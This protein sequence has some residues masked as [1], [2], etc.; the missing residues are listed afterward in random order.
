MSN[1][2]GN[3]AIVNLTNAQG[4]RKRPETMLDR[5]DIEG[6]N[7]TVTEMVG[8]GLD[9]VGAGYGDL[10]KIIRHSDYSITVRDFGRG[11]PLGWNYVAQ[12][13]NWDLVYNEMFAG[14]KY[15]DEDVDYSNIDQ[16]NYKFPIGTNGLGGFATQAT[17]MFF[18]VY[19]Y[20][21][22]EYI[23]EKTCCYM[24]FEEGVPVLKDLEVRSLEGNIVKFWKAVFFETGETFEKDGE[25]VKAK[26]VK[27]EIDHEEPLTDTE[28]DW[29][30]GT[31][32]H[33]RPDTVEVFS[34]SNTEGV[35]YEWILEN[36][37]DT[38]HLKQCDFEII[39]EASG[40]V[41]RIKGEGT[42]KLLETRAGSYMVPDSITKHENTI[43]GSYQKGNKTVKYLAKAEV[44]ICFTDDSSTRGDVKAIPPIV[45]HNSIKMKRGTPYMGY[46]DAVSMFFR[47][48]GRENNVKIDSSDYLR[49]ITAL[50]C[51][52]STNSAYE[53]QAK[54]GVSSTFLYD[55]VKNLTYE[56][57]SKEWGKGN[58]NLKYIVT[59]VIESAN[60]RIRIKEI[61]KQERLAKKASNV[62][63]TPNKF[64]ECL[65]NDPEKCE[66]WIPEGDS[67]QG[68]LESARDRNFQALLPIRGKIINCAKSSLDKVLQN[69]VIKDLFSVLGT[70]MDL[71]HSD[72]FNIEKLRFNKII[73]ATDADEDGYQIRILVFLVF[74]V[75]APELLRRG[76][77]YVAET[78]LFEVITKSGTFFAYNKEEY[79][80]LQKQ[81][82][83]SIIKVNR[84]KGLGQNDPD[85]LWQTTMCPETRR[86]VQL[87]IDIND[88]PSRTLIDMLFG[89]DVF[90]QRKDTILE[91][92]GS[93][94]GTLLQ[95]AEIDME[96]EVEEDEQE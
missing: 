65:W 3:N 85:M 29:N 40:T 61:E 37:K 52:Y 51:T 71:P 87:K 12:R 69:T 95:S 6:A 19:S 44:F 84:S 39:D 93:E 49:H 96:E 16:M 74:Y 25:I 11:V 90:K 50:I 73:I 67:A 22:I 9:E 81:Y 46:E 77:V 17:S 33:W 63:H 88:E 83:D 48:R 32:V 7:H 76:H 47:D 20:R 55:L 92:L 2:Y 79:Q 43:I 62:R 10:I 89:R 14:G 23:G 28:E 18:E 80:K 15:E 72:M 38:A 53:G 86:L 30:R 1:N 91:L 82:G 41:N 4:L 59:K 70:G 78:P 94:V 64:T 60:L 27:W 36:F 21:A 45:Y 56:A 57:L 26:D 5:R 35:S 42:E 24:R 8:N 13:W 34:E 54:G 68:A 31:L 75:L 66:V 58:K